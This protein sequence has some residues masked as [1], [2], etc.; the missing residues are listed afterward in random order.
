MKEPFDPIYETV[1]VEKRG[2]HVAFVYF[3]RRILLGW[4]G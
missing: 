1:A 3:F 4:L 2:P